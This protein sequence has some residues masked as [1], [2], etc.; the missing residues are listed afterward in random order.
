MDSESVSNFT[1]FDITLS[2][3]FQNQTCTNRLKKTITGYP[4]YNIGLSASIST[5]DFPGFLSE[6]DTGEPPLS[7]FA[8]LSPYLSTS[9][10][11]K[12]RSIL[13]V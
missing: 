1:Y 11:E 8:T 4:I 10:R 7:G 5:G 2:N 9:Y 12:T 3:F 13:G 6:S